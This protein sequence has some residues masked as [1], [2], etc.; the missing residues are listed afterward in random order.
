MRKL[1]EIINAGLKCVFCRLE[2]TN[3]SQTLIPQRRY[4]DII[5]WRTKHFLSWWNGLLCKVVTCSWEKEIEYIIYI[6]F[7]QFPFPKNRR[8]CIVIR[9]VM[10]GSVL[11]LSPFRKKFL[12]NGLKVYS[13]SNFKI[14]PL[15]WS[16]FE[17]VFF[18]CSSFLLNFDSSSF[19]LFSF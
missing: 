7:F 15:S 12:R 11:N 4:S 18:N 5:R 8:L 1:F 2:R 9:L 13:G 14:I 17:W 3:L 10:T 19:N 16:N 6:Y